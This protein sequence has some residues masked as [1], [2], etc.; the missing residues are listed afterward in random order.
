MRD[1]VDNLLNVLEDRE[2]SNTWV[3]PEDQKPALSP[4]KEYSVVNAAYPKAKV[5]QDVYGIHMVTYLVVDGV[6]MNLSADETNVLYR[7]MRRHIDDRKQE[8][9]KA[10]EEKATTEQADAWAYLAEDYD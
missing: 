10:S 8:Q 9:N 1:E 6:H 5:I 7:F 4:I 2:E 3:Y